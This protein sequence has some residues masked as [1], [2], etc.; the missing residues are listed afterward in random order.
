MS[1]FSRSN[2]TQQCGKL[3]VQTKVGPLPVKT[4]NFFR[5]N[6]TGSNSSVVACNTPDAVNKF[7]RYVPQ[8]MG[9]DEDNLYPNIQFVNYGNQNQNQYLL[10]LPP[11]MFGS[12][13]DQMQSY[14]YIG[15]MGG[16]RTRKNKGKS[17][18]GNKGRKSRRR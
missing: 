16:K 9:L 11:N 17:R 5:S 2:N 13:F 14:G 12:R 6:L 1:Y 7:M 4:K 8:L 15:A 3:F 18:K 10:T